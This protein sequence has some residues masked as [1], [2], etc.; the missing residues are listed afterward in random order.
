MLDIVHDEADDDV[1]YAG[2]LQS[3]GASASGPALRML[4]C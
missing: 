3:R 4:M 1:E 2:W